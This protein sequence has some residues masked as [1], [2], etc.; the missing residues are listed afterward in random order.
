MA[1]ALNS[2]K[3]ASTKL[4]N[5]TKDPNDI[6]LGGLAETAANIGIGA[7]FPGVGMPMGMIAHAFM[8]TTPSDAALKGAMT[9]GLSNLGGLFDSL[10]AMGLKSPASLQGPHPDLSVNAADVA[11]A[12]SMVDRTRAEVSD[13]ERGFRGVPGGPGLGVQGI[14]FSPATG[15]PAAA[16]SQMAA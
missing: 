13:I 7:G 15:A 4:G 5:T 3:A 1:T 16:S 9:M 8:G 2:P 6:S 12:G 10:E 14:G 11:D